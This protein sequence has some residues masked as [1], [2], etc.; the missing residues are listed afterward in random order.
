MGHALSW[1]AVSG[2]SADALRAELELL[3]TGRRVPTISAPLVGAELRAH[4]LL[5]ANDDERFVDDQLLAR[6][7]AGA[8]LVSCFVDEHVMVSRASGWKDGARLWSV[9][10]EPPIASPLTVEGT[11]PA[12]F[13]ALH[14]RFAEEQ[15]AARPDIDRLFELP[16]ELCR[17]L[18]GFRH[19]ELH[20][21]GFEVL[22]EERSKKPEPF[23]SRFFGR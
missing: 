8:E 17:A 9:T 12:P 21:E 1:I 6:V 13:E 22:F 11:P 10:R 16:A 7:S 19:T 4:V 23:W 5:L 14:A 18:V 2:K 15:R 3:P 20:A